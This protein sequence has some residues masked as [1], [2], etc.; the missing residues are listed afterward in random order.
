MKI[1]Q[2]IGVVFAIMFLLA[3]VSA[4]SID[5]NCTMVVEF[6]DSRKPLSI[7]TDQI[8]SVTFQPTFAEPGT[9]AGVPVTKGG[10]GAP[11]VAATNSSVGTA[12]PV[13]SWSNTTAASTWTITKTA[14]GEYFCQEAGLGNVNGKG[15]FTPSGTFRIEFGSGFYELRFA[16]DNRSA[17][18]YCNSVNNTFKWVKNN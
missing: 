9:P 13:G 11:I 2:V 10:S 16:P 7:P 14:S 8:R 4:M 1:V 18:G 5:Q 15:H 12:N 17:T 3:P 6:N